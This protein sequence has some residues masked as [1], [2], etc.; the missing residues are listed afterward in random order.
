MMYVLFI[1]SHL[2]HLCKGEFSHTYH[3]Y[4]KVKN[5][6]VRF[7]HLDFVLK[8]GFFPRSQ[9][10]TTYMYRHIQ[11]QLGFWSSQLSDKIS[12]V[13]FQR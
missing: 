5:K 4:V 2:P 13:V 7:V 3:I 6:H 11:K 10:P 1:F 12:Y 8:L 9:A